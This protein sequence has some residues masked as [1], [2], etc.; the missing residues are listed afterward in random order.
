MLK[1]RKAVNYDTSKRVPVHIDGIYAGYSYIHELQ[2]LEYQARMS[3][4]KKKASDSKKSYA[5][6]YAYYTFDVSGDVEDVHFYSGYPKSEEEY[7][8]LQDISDVLIKSVF[9]R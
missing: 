7:A 1:T 6:V 9:S 3:A 2:D 4:I 8:K 5:Y